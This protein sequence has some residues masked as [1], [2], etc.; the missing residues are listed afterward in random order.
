MT[1]RFHLTPE[2]PKPC[3][4]DPSK[5][6]ARGCSYGDSGHYSELSQASAAFEVS[7]GGALPEALSN[8]SS[9]KPT[10]HERAT[11]ELYGY[12]DEDTVELADHSGLG[13]DEYI[14]LSE[15]RENPETLANNCHAASL[16]IAEELE[17]DEEVVELLS[18]N[19]EDGYTHHAVSLKSPD[20]VEVIL[21]YTAAQYDS[22]LP[23]PFVAERARWQSTIEDRVLKKH[24]TKIAAIGLESEGGPL[25]LNSAVAGPAVPERFYHVA[26]KADLQS[27]LATGLQPAIGDRSETLGE[28]APRVYLFDSKISAE[29][30]G[31]N[32]LVDEFDEDEE[33]VLLSVGS[34]SVSQPSAT[35][36]YEDEE[37]EGGFGPSTEWTSVSSIPGT[38]LR[39][40]GDF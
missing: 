31:M 8:S 40:E 6:G 21:D 13:S 30:G 36:V 22:S 2:G 16:A 19:Y 11:L 32:W 24:G 27:I 28:D 26:R 3:S 17:G 34:D 9:P 20:G 15:L 37:V 39:F 1:T 10:V 33:F 18:I 4:A 25:P 38:A 12:I 14:T 5:P 35:Y 29:D 23:I 7:M